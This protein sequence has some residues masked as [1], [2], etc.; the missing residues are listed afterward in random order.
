MDFAIWRPINQKMRLQERR[1]HVSKR[2]T[3]SEYISRLRRVALSLPRKTIDKAIAHM[4]IRCQLLFKAKGGHFEE[5]GK[6]KAA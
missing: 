3:R 4:K 5:G 2:E 1:F 6:V